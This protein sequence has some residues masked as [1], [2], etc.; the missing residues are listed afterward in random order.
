VVAVKMGD[1][2]ACAWS[3][4]QMW[5]Q[6]PVEVAAIDPVGAGDA[7]DAG[8]IATLVRGGSVTDALALGT[9]CGAMVTENLGENT[10]FP[11]LADLP[12]PLMPIE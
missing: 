11:H 9:Y 4:G 3:A 7:F 8:F 6:A 10:G 1:Q 12:E 2:G 5:F